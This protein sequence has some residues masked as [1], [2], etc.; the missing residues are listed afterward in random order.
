MSVNIN[1]QQNIYGTQA[2]NRAKSDERLV[3][4]YRRQ[5]RAHKPKPNKVNEKT[6]GSYAASTTLNF[7]VGFHFQLGL[8]I[9]DK[10]VPRGI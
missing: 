4:R 6:I 3:W 5:A 9:Q 2:K 1:N 8:G 10:P 7:L